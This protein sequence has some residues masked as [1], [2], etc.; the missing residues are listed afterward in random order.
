M[1]MIIDVGSKE[2][3]HTVSVCVIPSRNLSTLSDLLRQP[4]IFVDAES[5]A[6]TSFARFVNLSVYY[7]KSSLDPG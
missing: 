4:T 7:R 6:Y 3:P 2:S 1:A 5:V